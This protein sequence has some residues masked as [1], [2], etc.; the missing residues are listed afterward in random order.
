MSPLI[1][2]GAQSS[3]LEIMFR[4]LIIVFRITLSAVLY[5]SETIKY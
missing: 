3:D 2:G 1:I 4:N 5:E